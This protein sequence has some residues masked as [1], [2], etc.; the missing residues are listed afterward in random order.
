[1]AMMAR[2]FIPRARIVA[3]PSES[4]TSGQICTRGQTCTRWQE[5]PV[6][7]VSRNAP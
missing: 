3:R 1:M 2:W 5:A 4:G 6:R 7:T